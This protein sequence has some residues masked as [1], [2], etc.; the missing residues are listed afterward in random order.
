M[1]AISRVLVVGYGVMGRGIAKSF[2]AAGFETTV[3]SRHPDK[4]KDVPPGE[5]ITGAWPKIHPT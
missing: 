1:G 4:A 5:T 2:A 3:L